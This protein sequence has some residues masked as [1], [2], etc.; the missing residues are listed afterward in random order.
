MPDSTSD[1]TV[2]QQREQRRAEKV[3]A[4]KAK[5]A[6]E[7]RNQR[8]GLI[9]AIVGGTAVVAIIV[10]VV[11]TSAT[12]PVDPATIEIEGLET[13]DG[14]ESLHVQT[15]VDYTMTPPAGGPHNPTW[16]NCGIYEEAVP[17]EYAV[18]SLEHSAVWVTYDPEQVQGA[19][20]DALRNAMPRSYIILSPF[21]GLEAPVVASAWGVQVALDGVDDPRLRDFIVKYRQ[22]PDAPEPGALCSQA[23]DGPGKIS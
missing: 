20:L 12:P 7:K 16:L 10:G 3:A 9:G 13:F 18:H 2:K 6:R 11:V 22:S 14:L 21:P 23:L 4:L 5:Q 17:A 1:L 8:L 15:A 19:D